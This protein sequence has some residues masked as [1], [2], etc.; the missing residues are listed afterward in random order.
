MNELKLKTSIV[1]NKS[2]GQNPQVNLQIANLYKILYGSIPEQFT[3]FSSVD[4]SDGTVQFSLFEFALKELEASLFKFHLKKSKT[5]VQ[6]Q[7]NYK[8]SGR[9]KMQEKTFCFLGFRY[10][11]AGSAVPVYESVI[12]ELI[13]SRQ[14][15]ISKDKVA[16]RILQ[17]TANINLDT[18][19]VSYA[20][21]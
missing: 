1:A 17:V 9:F 7:L 18:Q 15:E 5:A 13:S 11:K 2:R 6:H 3:C 10:T 14:R 16:P 8:P 20:H 19:E 12:P 21:I 4:P